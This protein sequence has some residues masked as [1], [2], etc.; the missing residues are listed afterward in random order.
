MFVQYCRFWISVTVSNLQVIKTPYSV[1]SRF[2]GSFV[3]V[4][5]NNQKADLSTTWSSVLCRSVIAVDLKLSQK[6]AFCTESSLMRPLMLL[7]ELSGHGVPWL[8]GTIFALINVTTDHEKEVF[9]NL[10]LGLI[11]DLVVIGILKVTFRR[12]RPVYNKKDMFLTVSVDNYSFPSGHATRCGMVMIFML[13]HLNLQLGIKLLIILWAVSVS[14]S[15]VVLGRHHISDVLVGFFVGILQYYWL[16][17][18]LW[19]SWSFFNRNIL[20]G[21]LNYKI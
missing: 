1:P 14:I 6:L 16:V 15:R 11:I 19:L 10:F 17:I 8:S 7:L 4:M 3:L 21:I 5:A 2:A 9:L 13:S 20:L 12:S 18:N